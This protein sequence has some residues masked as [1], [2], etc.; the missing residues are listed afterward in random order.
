MV[1]NVIRT[2]GKFKRFH[3]TNKIS[4]KSSLSS[5]NHIIEPSQRE[6]GRF[7]NE[8]KKSHFTVIVFL[9]R[10]Q[11]KALNCRRHGGH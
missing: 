7:Q 10:I 9:H 5:I 2:P 11:K 3:K 1:A 6:L 4:R 8:K